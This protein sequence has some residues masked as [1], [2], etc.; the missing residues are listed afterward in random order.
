MR[1]YTKHGLM[2]LNKMYRSVLMKCALANAII[3]LGAI[4]AAN[5]I[6]PTNGDVSSVLLHALQ[7]TPIYRG[8]NAKVSLDT[9]PRQRAWSNHEV[10][11]RLEPPVYW[12]ISI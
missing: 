3:F 7:K 10:C 4:G 8:L 12:G 9:V 6:E 1:Q 2:L 11:S 5:A